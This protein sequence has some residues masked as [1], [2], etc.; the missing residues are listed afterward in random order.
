MRITLLKENW[1]KLVIVIL[2][3]MIY[4]KI[5]NV[6]ENAFYTA[7]MVDASASRIINSL[8]SRLKS[9]DDGIDSMRRSF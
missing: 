7:D 1:F 4:L 3:V 2:L 9:I 5:A 6:N 8:D